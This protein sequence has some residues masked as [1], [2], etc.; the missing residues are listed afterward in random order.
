[1]LV[2]EKLLYLF[3][4]MEAPSAGFLHS[5]ARPHAHT[6]LPHR[7]LEQEQYKLHPLLLMILFMATLLGIYIKLVAYAEHKTRL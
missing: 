1:M 4:N 5:S 6:V 3:M 7:D 2:H